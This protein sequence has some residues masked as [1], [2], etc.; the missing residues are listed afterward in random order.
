MIQ[1]EDKSLCCGCTACYSVCPKHAISMENDYEGFSYP[2][3]NK[4]KCVDC[5]LCN[6]ICPITK[7][8]ALNSFKREAYVIRSTERNI[9]SK[10]T[11]GGFVS[12]LF[13][14]VIKQGGVV[15]G[16][17]YD[18]EYRVT[19]K[20][21]GGGT[22]EDFQGSKYVQSDLNNC[23]V[24]IKDYLEHGRLVCFV[25]TTCQVYGLKSFLQKEYEQLITVDLV[26]H[27]VPSPKFWDK[28]LNNQKRKY[29]SEIASVAFRNKTYGYHS[30][31]MRIKFKNGKVYLGSARIDPMLKCFF[32][33]LSSRPS[34]YNCQF[35]T[36]E[37]YSD[38]TIYDCWSAE[39]LV[40]RLED[41]NKGFTN[42]IVQSS[43]GKHVLEEIK[44]RYECYSSD[45]D[46]ASELDGIMI[47]KSAVPHIRRKEF[48]LDIDKEP[49]Y[50]HVKRFVQI[51]PLDYFVEWSK[52]YVYRMGIYR[53]LKRKFR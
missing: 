3:V 49:F 7:N 37:R 10:S 18:E 11:S 25:G 15:C 47:R 20:I 21:M 40:D 34:C 38:F 17:T 6:N 27:G 23:F 46:M 42:L 26:C 35:K 33:G 19:H 48:Y 22:V 44:E 24:E 2:K 53:Y 29:H 43:K 51:T 45:V 1:I 8:V 52:K 12:P 13:E 30:S 50:S 4:S 41:D 36:L 28:Y 32:E 14:W 39:K 16:A 31:T 5:G 9:V